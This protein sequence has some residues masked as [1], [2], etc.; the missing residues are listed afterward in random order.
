[1]LKKWEDAVFTYGWAYGST[2]DK[3]HGKELLITVSTGVS[4]EDYAPDGNFK[5]T[6][7]ELLRP[8]QATSNL[9]GTRYLTPYI[10]YRVQSDEQLEQYAKEYVAYV[11][12]PELEQLPVR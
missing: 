1:M 10:L 3:L 2:G 4:K 8:L 9:I 5:Y 11:L 7:P 6:V 12:N